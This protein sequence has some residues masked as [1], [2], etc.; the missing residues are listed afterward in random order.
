MTTLYLS[1][2][3][4][5]RKYQILSGYYLQKLHYLVETMLKACKSVQGYYHYVAHELFAD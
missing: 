4:Q 1:H 2:A 3:V 5:K